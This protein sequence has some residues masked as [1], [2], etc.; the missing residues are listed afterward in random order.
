MAPTVLAE[1]LSDSILSPEVWRTL[2]DIPLIAVKPGYWRRAGELRAKVLAKGRKPR[3]GDALVAQSCM[4]ESL[5]LINRD[6]DFSAPLRTRRLS[7]S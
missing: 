2:A 4:D 7:T 1:L 6:R 3:L 5:F